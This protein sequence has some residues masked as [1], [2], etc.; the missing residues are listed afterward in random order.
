MYIVRI[1]V[2]NLYN[3]DLHQYV[4]IKLVNNY[5]CNGIILACLFFSF[6]L[7]YKVASAGYAVSSITDK[8][9]LLDVL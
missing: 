7:Y 9:L 5:N 4:R 1:V 2:L 6:E 3:C 8:F